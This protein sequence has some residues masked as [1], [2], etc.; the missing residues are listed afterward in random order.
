MNV[1]D[2]DNEVGFSV[3]AGLIQRLGLE[4]VGRAETAVSELIKNSYD[5]DATVVDVDFIEAAKAGGDLIISDNGVGMTSHQLING[6]M[7]I[8]STDKIHNPSS[9]RFNRTKAGKKGIGRFAAQR[10]GRKLIII[11]QTKD[12][13]SA[14]K[15]EIDWDLYSIDKDLSSIK[16]PVEIIDK[17]KK[18]GTT[19]IIKNLREKWTEAA[20][21][22]VYRYVLDL[23]QPDYLSDRSRSNNLAVQNEAS[24]KVNF[25][26][27]IGDAKF[28]LINDKISI[29]DKS[30]AVFEGLIDENHCGIVSIKSET[31]EINDVISIDFSKDQKKYDDLKDVYFKIHYFI[32]NRPQYYK[33][34]ISSVD[35]NKIQEL[36]K[37]ASGVRLY[38]NGFRVLP[39][40][41]ATDDWTNIDRRWSSES[42]VVNVPL[43]NKNLFG[44]VEIVD[45][46]GE[47]FEETSSREGLLENDAFR[48]L[49]D[50]VNKS[51]VAAR[52]RI[53]EKITAFKDEFDKDDPTR[54]SDAKAR[55]TQ[56]MFDE[57]K[58]LLDKKTQKDNTDQ[59]T[60][61]K[62]NNKK[63]H[64]I[65]QHLSELIEEAGMLRVLAGLGLT[66]GEFTHEI[67]QFRPS[68]YGC[69]SKLR[70]IIQDE[71][72]LSVVNSIKVDFD[73]LFDYTK[74]F[75]STISE[76]TNREKKPVDLLAVLDQF[77]KTIK[78]D[79]EQNMIH[80]DV[81]PRDYDVE[82]VAMH[83][84]EWNSILFNLYT[85]A[86]KAIKRANV[87]GRILVEVGIEDHSVFLRFQDNGDGIPKEN[88]K[89][90]F[91]AFFSTS[92]PAS[93]DAPND[94]QLIGTGLGLKIVKDIILSYNG[95]IIIDAPDN[96]FST[97][98]KITIPKQ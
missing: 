48:Q 82:T 18:E 96:G 2:I 8:S 31:L 63:G 19:L 75:S 49:S 68:V 39:Y 56:E 87:L 71:S 46:K 7:R 79:S 20:I 27:I 90:V 28:P 91:N 84:S 57:L 32:Y 61:D 33:D 37:T 26:Q 70:E 5:A 83:R 89:R 51:L 53:A 66:I 55:S 85:N 54:D 52:G 1:N 24:F 69:I 77:K 16:F 76:N 59:S 64:E 10:L 34:K 4:L 30:L 25:N 67:K 45:S 15:I 81:D 93:F 9:M 95:S 88:Q 12:F 65:I 62:E 80:F 6:F 98:I 97:C 3:D 60:E 14:I 11:T 94:E 73:C 44:F 50:F 29:F 74:Y 92:T 36:S 23:F 42:G 40:G 13:K 43:S 17:Q 58:Q 35:L 41:E 38:R 78:N 86:K 22:R 47:M 21:K 72:I